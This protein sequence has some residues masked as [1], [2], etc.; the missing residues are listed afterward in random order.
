[1]LA[2]T[3]LMGS[4]AAYCRLTSSTSLDNTTFLPVITV[5]RQMAYQKNRAECVQYLYS[6]TLLAPKMLIDIPSDGCYARNNKYRRDTTRA[7]V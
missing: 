5:A 2:T 6:L 1:V 4:Y 7:S 3:R